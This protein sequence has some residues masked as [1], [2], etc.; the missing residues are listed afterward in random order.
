M[1]PRSNDSGQSTAQLLAQLADG[2]PDGRV[3]IRDLLAA[4]GRRAF[5]VL[6]LGA[7]ILAMN[8]VPGL[9][10]GLSGPLVIL[11]GLQLVFGRRRPVLPKFLQRKS[12]RRSFFARARVRVEPWIG[13]I[14]R[15]IRPRLT[16]LFD[17]YG[18]NAISGILLTVFG[19]LV[20]LPI[21]FTNFAFG[22]LLLSYCIAY[23]ERDG[24][25]LVLNWAITFGVI[26]VFGILS[27]TLIRAA[28]EW[29][30]RLL[31]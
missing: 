29:S 22:V 9:A 6:F 13:R 26:L 30:T 17:Q 12:V 21:P 15:L 23:I 20:L 28:T 14:E 7:G 19:V 25:L 1:Q 5:A 8:P 2:D 16:F 24:V 11:A 18:W 10:G 4:F 27:G 31:G 3:E